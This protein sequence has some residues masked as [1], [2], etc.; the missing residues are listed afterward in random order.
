M[1]VREG[2][3]VNLRARVM[4]KIFRSSVAGRTSLR[5]TR[6]LNILKCI[7]GQ[8]WGADRRTLLQLYTSLIRPI[9]D[10]NGFLFDEIASS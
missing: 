7:A 4:M 2:G 5:C 8:D 1:R 9:L 6:R 10:Y 3:K